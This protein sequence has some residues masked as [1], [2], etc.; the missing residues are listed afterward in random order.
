MSRQRPTLAAFALAGVTVAFL[1]MCGGCQATPQR[2]PMLDA[3]ADNSRRSMVA[4]TLPPELA[5]M[6]RASRMDGGE[7]TAQEGIERPSG[8]EQPGTGA[9]SQPS[10]HAPD[11]ASG[12]APAPRVEAETAPPQ[13]AM[14]PQADAAAESL[15]E[16]A[17]AA[18]SGAST[19]P[20]NSNVPEP[21]TPHVPD[22]GA[23]AAM[24]PESSRAEAEAPTA[25][26]ESLP[27]LPGDAPAA[28]ASDS[29][30]PSLPADSPAPPAQEP[31][32]RRPSAVAFA[33]IPDLPVP[34]LDT[35]ARPEGVVRA[36]KG[37]PEKPAE[38][39]GGWHQVDKDHGS[40]FLPGGYE[41]STFLF[42]PEG[43]VEVQRIFGK[44]GAISQTWRIGYE[45]NKDK[46]V[47]TLGRDPGL[48]PAPQSLQGFSAGDVVVRAP[49]RSFP[50]AL[51]CVRSKD[52]TVRLGDKVYAQ[53]SE[54]GDKPSGKDS[55]TE[56]KGQ[57]GES[58]S[59]R[60]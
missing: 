18:D 44:G 49:V 20:Q 11:S 25:P 52:G 38:V 2:A 48:R 27:T 57:P 60:G 14:P 5:D 16:P 10:P 55:Q 1:L 9:V 24:P 3:S 58:S 39:R 42:R 23:E 45:W 6:E 8:E 26:P 53:L 22:Q 35:R 43:I 31:L 34:P 32:P 12:E 36:P 15:G 37:E 59:P 51:H 19:E 41:S 17:S 54:G 7:E 47:L 33:D 28:P 29:G 46:S 56:K 40:D 50:I 4:T 13:G 30:P 21:P